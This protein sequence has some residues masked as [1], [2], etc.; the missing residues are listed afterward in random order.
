MPE[1]LEAGWRIGSNLKVTASLKWKPF[2]SPRKR[3]VE[4]GVAQHHH[5]FNLRLHKATFALVL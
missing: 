2:M 5:A 1:E 4:C 3:N